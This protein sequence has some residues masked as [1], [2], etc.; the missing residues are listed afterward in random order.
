VPFEIDF[1]PVDN[2]EVPGDAVV[3][4]YGSSAQQKIIVYDAGTETTGDALVKHIRQ[5]FNIN[6]I[7][8][9]VSSHPD[10]HNTPGLI[11]LLQQM[12][13]GTLWMHR[14]WLYDSVIRD[15]FELGICAQPG[16]AETLE[17]KFRLNYELEQLAHEKQVPIKE[18]FRG[19][20][21][22][23]FH[24]LSPA[25]DWYVHELIDQL[26][27][28][29]ASPNHLTRF[30]RCLRRTAKRAV[31]WVAEH[32]D[33]EYLPE[34]GQTSAENESSVVLY[35][36]LEDY[37]YG[38]L[39]T[40]HAGV[41]ALHRAADYL[42]QLNMSAEKRIQF[43]QMPHYGALEHV[44]TP[45]LN[46]LLGTPLAHEPEQKHKVAFISSAKSGR[47]PHASVVNALLRRG[48][49]VVSTEGKTKRHQKNAVIPT[50]W[51]V[52][53]VLTFSERVEKTEL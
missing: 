42:E 36:N 3:L 38:L 13:V 2:G 49:K 39:L 15:Y 44:S 9:L 40:G 48:V 43:I 20:W 12:D 4:R 22:G 51:Q 10:P 7:D 21:I 37:H 17:F 53:P 34:S 23:N 31:A 29:V 18:P 35:G 47:Y 14:P 8:H 5:F 28:P 41:E 50:N 46:R 11:N 33:H 27:L 26:S 45:L 32:W 1:L 24:V 52:S 30:L 6:H 25:K 19:Q 16:L